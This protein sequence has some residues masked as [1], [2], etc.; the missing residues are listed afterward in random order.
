MDH[1]ELQ[2]RLEDRELLPECKQF[3]QKYN[4]RDLT[5]NT[6]GK[7]IMELEEFSLWV[8]RTEREVLK[9]DFEDVEDYIGY[10]KSRDLKDHSAENFVSAISLFYDRLMKKQVIDSNPVRKLTLSDYFS[11]KESHQVA[12]LKEEDGVVWLTPSEIR[13]LT[14]NVPPP[15]TRNKLII[16]LLFQT[17]I[18]RQEIVDIELDDIDQD[19]R[20]I[21]IRGK[22]EKNR[23]V[24]YTSRL[25]IL[26]DEWIDYR[27]G[28]SPYADESNYLLLSQTGPQLKANSIN[29]IVDAAAQEAGLQ[30]V[31]YVDAGGAER[32]KITAHSLRHSFAVEYLSQGGKVERL[33]KILGHAKLD[34]TQRYMDVVDQ[35]VEDDYKGLDMGVAMER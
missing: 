32:K 7:R 31:L 5:D 27:R 24:Y 2:S 33:Q 4:N 1:D 3:L 22:G 21:R 20:K 29:R 23:T 9:L 26:L 10:L 35:D 18:R 16:Q 8:E 15:A 17:G 6:V 25:N 12:E 30:E 28:I 13:Q 11:R 19:E 14:E 34:T